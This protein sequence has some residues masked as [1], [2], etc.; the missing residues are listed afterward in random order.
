[1]RL[2]RQDLIIATLYIRVLSFYFTAA[3]RS[4]MGQRDYYWILKNENTSLHLW[5]H[6]IGS[7]C[8]IEIDFKILLLVY[9]SLHDL[10]PTHLSALLTE[11]QAGRTLRSS[12]RKLLKTPRTRLSQKGDRAFAVVAPAQDCAI[13]CHHMLGMLTLYAFKA[14]LKTYLFAMAYSS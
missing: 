14:Q 10:T 5:S 8:N 6:Y 12:G 3:K 7:L 13:V 2:Y 11:Y 9:K 4:R 1:M